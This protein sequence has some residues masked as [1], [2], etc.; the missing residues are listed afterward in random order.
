MIRRLFLVSALV[1]Q[2]WVD[3]KVILGNF[4]QDPGSAVVREE[5]AVPV[6]LV[7]NLALQTFLGINDEGAFVEFNRGFYGPAVTFHPLVSNS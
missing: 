4:G 1:L 7:A 3:K 5:G 6:R 2:A